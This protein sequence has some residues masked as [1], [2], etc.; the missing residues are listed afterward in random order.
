MYKSHSMRRNT[1]MNLANPWRQKCGCFLVKSVNFVRKGETFNCWSLPSHI[2]FSC[3][4]T[5]SPVK[6]ALLSASIPPQLQQ[7]RGTR[8][9]RPA[10]S[11]TSNRARGRQGAPCRGYATRDNWRRGCTPNTWLWWTGRNRHSGMRGERQCI[12]STTSHPISR[13]PGGSLPRRSHFHH[14]AIALRHGQMSH[15]QPSMNSV[16]SPSSWLPSCRTSFPQT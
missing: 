7:Q 13:I 9:R 16:P 14:M 12:T 6:L 4:C 5:N 15:P 8:M 11:P 2:Q 1:L 10:R 3:L